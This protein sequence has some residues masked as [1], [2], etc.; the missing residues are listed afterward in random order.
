MGFKG[1]FFTSSYNICAKMQG[2]TLE[3][4]PRK[5]VCDKKQKHLTKRHFIPLEMWILDI[6]YRY[7]LIKTIIISG[8]F[9]NENKLKPC[10]LCQKAD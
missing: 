4:A 10:L 5:L 8:L 7:R 6:L 1:L 2:A 3:A 9:E